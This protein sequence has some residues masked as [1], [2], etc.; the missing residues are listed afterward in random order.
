[1]K[2]FQNFFKKIK[3]KE[4]TNEG[5]TDEEYNYIINELVRR[6]QDWSFVSLK[7]RIKE[8]LS[9]EEIECRLSLDQWG[10]GG[11]EVKYTI[12]LIV[13]DLVQILGRIRRI[14]SK[15]QIKKGRLKN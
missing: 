8:E 10:A 11:L 15:E 3:E 5:I 6:F 7:R 9:K 14:N 4:I 1:M 13:N 2:F 12:S